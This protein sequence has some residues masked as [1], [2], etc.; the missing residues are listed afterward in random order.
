MESRSGS[1]KQESDDAE[2]LDMTRTRLEVQQALSKVL[3]RILNASARKSMP[4]LLPR[5]EDWSLQNYEAWNRSRFPTEERFKILQKGFLDAL[6]NTTSDVRIGNL[7]NA[8]DTDWFPVG[9]PTLQDSDCSS[10]WL[11][12]GW[13]FSGTATLPD[14]S[15]FSV[16]YDCE[17][18]P[19]ITQAGSSQVLTEYHL[20][21]ASIKFS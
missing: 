17:G 6:S 12:L 20:S 3:E 21:N 2:T 13:D 8:S 19:T 14:I 11:T 1:G 15:T 10:P 7:E 4:E 5:A 16:Y 18:Y 9:F